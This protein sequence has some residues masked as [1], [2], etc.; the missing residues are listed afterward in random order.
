[1]LMASAGGQAR[2]RR[3]DVLTHVTEHEF[4]EADVGGLPG[5][6]GDRAADADEQ[7]A[8]PGGVGG[9]H[10]GVGSLDRRG[11]LARADQDHV[12]GEHRVHV[13]AQLDLGH[14]QQDEVVAHPLDVGDQMR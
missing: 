10:E 1:M 5:G 14:G 3:P 9:L 12:P 7:G 4:F 13:A 2:E 6:I 11:V 8:L